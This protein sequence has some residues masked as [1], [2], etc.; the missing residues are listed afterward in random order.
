ML[1]ASNIRSLQCSLRGSHPTASGCMALDDKGWLARRHVRCHLQQAQLVVA[2]LPAHDYPAWSVHH[3]HD[4]AKTPQQVTTCRTAE[5]SPLKIYADGG[6]ENCRYNACCTARAREHRLPV[7]NTTT[8][9]KS[10]A[11]IKSA[12][13]KPH[14]MLNIAHVLLLNSKLLAL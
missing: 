11:V 14:K 9:F 8:Q 6:I 12:V 1:C 3:R 2:A 4:S 7:P 10:T 13:S 5:T